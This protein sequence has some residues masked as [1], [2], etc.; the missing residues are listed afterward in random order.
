MIV[1][2]RIR[3]KEKDASRLHI[4]RQETVQQEG[5]RSNDGWPA[6]WLAGLTTCNTLT[7]CSLYYLHTA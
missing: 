4:A 7:V 1:T 2:K 3:N 6:G 5:Q